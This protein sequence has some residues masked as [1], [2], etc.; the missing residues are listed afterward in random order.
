[1][2]TEHAAHLVPMASRYGTTEALL[3][4]AAVLM[5]ADLSDGQVADQ[6]SALRVRLGVRSGAITG[7]IQ[8]FAELRSLVRK[9]TPAAA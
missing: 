1:M 6:L 9:P 4:L 3:R 8:A 2:L 5:W 7:A